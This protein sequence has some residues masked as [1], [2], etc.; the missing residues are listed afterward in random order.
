MGGMLL[1][2]FLVV[3]VFSIYTSLVYKGPNVVVNIL[4]ELSELL[5]KKEL[6]KLKILWGKILIYERPY[7][8]KKFKRD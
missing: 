2:K 1:K 6:E 8:I 7:K 4:S 3:V 5:K